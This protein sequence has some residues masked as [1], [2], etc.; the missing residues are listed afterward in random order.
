MDFS[1]S[2]MSR[3]GC[4]NR[5]FRLNTQAKPSVGDRRLISGTIRVENATGVKRLIGM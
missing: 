2:E 5:I 3:F 1:G 4:L